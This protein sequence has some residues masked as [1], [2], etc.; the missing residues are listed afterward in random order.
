VFIVIEIIVKTF[1]ETPSILSNRRFKKWFCAGIDKPPAG[2]AFDTERDSGPLAVC[3]TAN[4]RMLKTAHGVS[5]WEVRDLRCMEFRMTRRRRV[6]PGL[7][8]D[9]G[10][11]I[12]GLPQFAGQTVPASVRSNWPDN[13]AS[14]PLRTR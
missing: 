1:S 9:C 5:E 12:E 13:K 4:W 10:I 8:P 6:V 14:I 7:L 2:W 11:K 3:E